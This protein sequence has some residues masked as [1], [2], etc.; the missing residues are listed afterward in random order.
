[1]PRTA[2]NPDH[3]FD[4]PWPAG[5]PLRP[6]VGTVRRWSMRLLLVVL[7]AVIG[8]YAF[9][10]ESGRVKAMAEAYLADVL[11]ARVVVGKARLS[12]FE[13]LRL[14]DVAVY[15]DEDA[16]SPDS[17]IFTAAAFKVDY[18]PRSILTGKLEARQIVAVAPHVRLVENR[19]T[20]QWNYQRLLLNR[21]G[22][23]SAPAGETRG[24]RMGGGPEILPE[25][26]LRDARID[27]SEIRDGQLS[28][29]GSMAM[30]GRLSPGSEVGRYTFDL[31]SRGPTEGVGAIIKG[32]IVPATGQFNLRMHDF[33]FGRD[34]LS[35]M[36]AEVRKWCE[37]HQLS[38]RVDI[39]EMSFTPGRGE[40]RARF[41]IVA[42]LQGVTLA[43]SPSEWRS[44]H[45]NEAHAAALETLHLA[46][47]SPFMRSGALAQVQ[48]M[49]DSRPIRLEQVTGTFV[50]DENGIDIPVL[51]ARVEANGLKVTGHIDGYSPDAPARIHLA[52]LDSENIYIPH[53]PTYI[54]SLPS[55]VREVY[56]HLR[57]VGAA[58]LDFELLREEPGGRPRLSGEVRIVDGQFTF[59][60]F[61]YP[62]RNV[63]G[64]IILGTNPEKGWEQLELRDLRGYGIAG[65]PNEN[66]IVNIK[67][68]IGPLGPESAVNIEVTGKN[69]R[70]EPAVIA[71]LPPEARSALASLDAEGQGAYPTFRLDFRCDVI[72]PFGYRTKWQVNT[73][74]LIHEADGALK[75]FP[76]PLKGL[77]GLIRVREG[78]LEI[79]DGKMT[80]GDAQLKFAGDFS[81]NSPPREEDNPD[82]PRPAPRIKPNLAISARN[83]PIDADL[84]AALPEGRRKWVEKLGVGGRLDVDGRVIP[85]DGDSPAGD[86]G[87]EFALSLRDG[88]LTPVGDTPLVRDATARL[89]VTPTRIILSDLKGKRGEAELTGQG[90]A[91]WVADAPQLNLSVRAANLELDEPLYAALPKPAQQGWDAVRPKGTVDVEVTYS[92]DLGKAAEQQAAAPQTAEPPI[93]EAAATT[94]PAGYQVVIR[95]RT[96]SVTPTVFPYP[97]DQVA[98]MVTIEG[99]HVALTDITARHGDAAVS[100]GGTG[101]LGDESQWDVRI[102]AE[103]VPVDEALITALPEAL[104]DL[105]KKL[106]IEGVLSV[107]FDRFIYR[108]EPQQFATAA[109]VVDLDRP[110]TRASGTGSIDFRG[111]LRF[112]NTKLNVGVPME[113]VVGHLTLEG[114]THRGDLA[115][116]SGDLDV[117]SLMMAGRE[118]KNLRAELRKTDLQPVLRIDKLRGQLAGGEVAGN[119]LLTYPKEGAS[120]Y[121]LELALRN[122]DVRQLTGGADKEISGELAAS[123]A[124]E[125]AWNDPAS[126]RGRGEVVVAG[127]QMYQIPVVLGLLEIT[128]LAL[129]INS[130][131]KTASTRY[132]LTGTTVTFE[133]IE[134]RSDQMRM[135]GSGSIDFDSKR[136]RL[137][138]TTDNPNWPKLP[139]IGDI[140]Q[141]ARNDLLQIHVT[142]TVQK[143]KVSASSMNTFQTTIDEVVGGG[144]SR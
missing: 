129:P 91:T 125:G 34:V 104:A 10:T 114:N 65:G 60:K 14:D 67:G 46:Q 128:N 84:L 27:Y 69:V 58:R 4:R 33:D 92:G 47:L 19:D 105:V 79:V 25:I 131:F 16:S 136:V 3:L 42:S 57:P 56:N 54:Y 43:V 36:P 21:A 117:Q 45:E 61:P 82:A 107:E 108:D 64:R 130:P 77:S 6:R 85:A 39:P 44:R 72:R 119:V 121:A 113:Q 81:W 12:I 22:P 106:T 50:F 127:R 99:P 55:A 90:V 59:D 80:R 134:L 124:L 32:S 143:P 98:G 86:Y 132:S 7:L 52:S 30:E 112:E 38:G 11:K 13:G 23:T 118:A 109:K 70:H 53:S 96:L 83:V 28:A 26:I 139:V 144:G 135:A 100:L 76:Y 40:S 1:M 140:I 51:R 95:P 31:Q 102:K 88:T 89:H 9:V 35:M 133:Q 48:A 97:L 120:R 122:A 41:R 37:D 74:L 17:A 62:L 49:F 78:K 68:L 20:G 73:E 111:L 15:V 71:A 63:T 123:L 94:Q 87:F 101:L 29:R 115:A 8:T 5:H 24:G 75:A 66:S 93:T 141:G 116:F 103:R 126:R 138:F 142:G 2:P 110:T 18:S 137:S